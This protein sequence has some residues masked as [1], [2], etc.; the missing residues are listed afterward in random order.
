MVLN[1]HVSTMMECINSQDIDIQLDF[2]GTLSA[3]KPS[4]NITSLCKFL[5]MF[6]PPPSHSNFYFETRGGKN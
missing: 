5:V 6:W 2:C 1:L 4:V 3:E